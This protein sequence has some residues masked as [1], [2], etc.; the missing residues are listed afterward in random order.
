MD[1]GNYDMWR[2]L[3]DSDFENTFSI[4]T[5]QYMHDSGRNKSNRHSNNMLKHTKVRRGV[6]GGKS[7]S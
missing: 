2:P 7:L 4:S 1:P 5:K 3:I 6:D